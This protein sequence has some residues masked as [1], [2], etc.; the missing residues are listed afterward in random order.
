MTTT[1]RTVDQ[2]ARHN[3]LLVVECVPCNK[4]AR[5]LARDIAI[6]L[7][8]GRSIEGLPFTCRDCGA[9]ASRI[10]P[11]EYDLG[12]AN[13]IIVWRPTRLR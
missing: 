12:R 11:Y 10:T 3:M 13:E 7:G 5:F 9:R 1:I 4:S 2:A 6:W 8:Y